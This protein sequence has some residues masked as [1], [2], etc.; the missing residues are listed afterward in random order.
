MKYFNSNMAQTKMFFL[1]PVVVVVF[2]LLQTCEAKVMDPGLCSYKEY[3]NH[4][5]SLLCGYSTE[6]TMAGISCD[7]QVSL[8]IFLVNVY[9]RH[10]MFLVL[11]VNRFKIHQKYM[12]VMKRHHKL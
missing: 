10:S 6:A 4:N 1:W 8:S 3:C 7:D 11:G 2:V 9:F 12:V 5:Q